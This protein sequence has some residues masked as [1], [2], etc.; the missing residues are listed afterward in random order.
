MILQTY[1]NFYILLHGMESMTDKSAEK[2]I[3]KIKNDQ[4]FANLLQ[5]AEP[6]DR[7][8]IIS[9][10]GFDFTNDELIKVMEEVPDEELAGVIGGQWKIESK[11]GRGPLLMN[12][13]GELRHPIKRE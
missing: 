10:A 3:E 5:G 13:S 11:E 9:G 8:K 6:A 12:E 1:S 4:A 2:F 7:S